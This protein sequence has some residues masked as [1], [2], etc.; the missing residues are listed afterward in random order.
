VLSWRMI[1][2]EIVPPNISYRGYSLQ[3]L[4]RPPQWQV[5][6]APMLTERPELAT[7]KRIVRG[8]NEEDVVKRAKVRVDD[9]MDNL[10]LH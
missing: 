9:M 7:E 4:H 8:W 2:P 10:G 1:I 5:V 6:I 3:L